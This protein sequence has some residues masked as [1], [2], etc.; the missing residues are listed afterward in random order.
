MGPLLQ[1][2]FRE[3]L[4]MFGVCVLEE[5]PGSLHS[6]QG[7]PAENKRTHVRA[8]VGLV[9]HVGGHAFAGNVIIYVPRTAQKHPLAGA[10]VWYGRVQ[11]HHIEGIIQQTILRGNI[12]E[13]LLR[14]TVLA[15]NS[16]W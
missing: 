12:I 3:K 6:K 13:E 2:E 15:T 14:G 7:V 1:E 11:P 9:S 8:R 10:G 4:H 16:N 5:S